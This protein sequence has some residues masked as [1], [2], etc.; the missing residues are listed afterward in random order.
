MAVSR[1]RDMTTLEGKDG[2]L[3]YDSTDDPGSDGV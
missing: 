2:N 1:S 3:F